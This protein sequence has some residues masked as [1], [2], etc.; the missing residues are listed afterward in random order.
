MGRLSHFGMCVIPGS[1]FPVLGKNVAGAKT[2]VLLKKE[3]STGKP[4]KMA[5]R[6]ER[7]FR[8]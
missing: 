2:P 4:Q 1:Q 8:G 6:K 5:K 7:S 3:D